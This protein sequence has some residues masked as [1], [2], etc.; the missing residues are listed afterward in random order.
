VLA[1]EYAGQRVRG[2]GECQMRGDVVDAL[3]FEPQLTLGTAESL[4][5]LLACASGHGSTAPVVGAR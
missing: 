2:A 5:K 4:E 3:A 1:V